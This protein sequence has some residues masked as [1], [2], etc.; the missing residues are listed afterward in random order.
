[1]NTSLDYVEPRRLLA[2]LSSDF[3]S[4]RDIARAV[5]ANTADVIHQLCFLRS[6]E[7]RCVPIM[8]GAQCRGTR[9]EY[10]LAEVSA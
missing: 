9:Y 3:R 5:G 4:A 7:L 1:M 6:A 8:R 2:E 10:R